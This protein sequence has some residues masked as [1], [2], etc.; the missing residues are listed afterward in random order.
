MAGPLTGLTIRP[1]VDVFRVRSLV[2]PAARPAVAD[3]L[4][5]ISVGPIADFSVVSTCFNSRL[6]PAA[7]TTEDWRLVRA[8]LDR[9]LGSG[10]VFGLS[11][12]TARGDKVGLNGT[13][14]IDR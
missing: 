8:T 3:L 14:S 13:T 6:K 5:G 11:R 10:L 12:V 9:I 7:G 1:G 2:G 4:I